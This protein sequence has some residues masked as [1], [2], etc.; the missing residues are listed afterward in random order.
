MTCK[1]GLKKYIAMCHAMHDAMCRAEKIYSVQLY[2]TDSVPCTHGGCTY[3]R[4]SITTFYQNR[5]VIPRVLFFKNLIL[6]YLM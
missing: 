4:L 3:T 5:T 2:C 6:Q 1:M